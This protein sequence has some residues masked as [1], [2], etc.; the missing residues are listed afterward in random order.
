VIKI[1]KSTYK[2]GDGMN[3]IIALFMHVL[4]LQGYIQ[5]KVKP[6][7]YRPTYALRAAGG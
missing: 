7:L 6:S 5:V 4:A 2:G 1:Y 3:Q